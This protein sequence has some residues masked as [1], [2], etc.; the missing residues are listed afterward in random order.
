MGIEYSIATFGYGSNHDEE[1]LSNMANFK[2]G[3]FYFIKN[4]EFVAETFIESLGKL[5]T[6]IAKNAQITVIAS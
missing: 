4:N 3:D 5:M 6:V 2:N 1:V